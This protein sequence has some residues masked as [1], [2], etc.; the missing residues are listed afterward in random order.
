MSSSEL[1]G[2]MMG[3]VQSRLVHF[4][5]RFYVFNVFGFCC[6]L[7]FRDVTISVWSEYAFAMDEDHQKQRQQRGEEAG[8]CA[9]DEQLGALRLHDALSAEQ[10]GVFLASML[11]VKC[12]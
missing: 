11:C 12:F 9:V 6:G 5:H 7:P 4:W 3:S 8:V 1:S 10:V 2:C